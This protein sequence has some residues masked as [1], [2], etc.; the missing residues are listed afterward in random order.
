MT[1]WLLICNTNF[2]DIDKLAEDRDCIDWQ[3]KG[4]KFETGDIVYFYCT[5]PMSR[6][7][8]KGVV[9]GTDI[10]ESEIT[11]DSI[12]WKNREAYY[13]GNGKWICVRITAASASDG[14]KLD[15]LKKHGFKGAVQS[16]SRLHSQNIIDY[17]DSHMSSTVDN[18]PDS[19]GIDDTIIEGAV[20]KVTVNAY[21]RNPLA[22]SKC[23]DHY[24]AICQICGIDFGKTY[25]QFASGFINVHHIVPIHEIKEEYTVDPINDLIPVCPN[26]HAMLHRKR[27]DGTCYSVEELKSALVKH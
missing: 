6:I 14:L 4:N 22:R 1:T 11:D 19:E 21:E 10:E 26:C 16:P 2:F 7:K 3:Q 25:G 23:I 27:E 12:Y 17:I 18:Y 9:I 13:K 24:G 20:K 5:K 15:E 8:Y